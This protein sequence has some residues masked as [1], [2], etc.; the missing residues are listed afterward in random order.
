MKNISLY[1]I[2]VLLGFNLSC[3]SS[4]KKKTNPAISDSNFC[5]TLRSSFDSILTSPGISTLINDICK[6]G[7]QAKIDKIMY[8]DPSDSAQIISKNPNENVSNGYYRVYFQGGISLAEVP[9]SVYF[10]MTKTQVK[11]EL[12]AKLGGHYQYDPSINY[13]PT[14]KSESKV[15]YIYQKMEANNTPIEY[16]GVT[17]FLTLGP[18]SL[19]VVVNQLDEQENKKHSFKEEVLKM[20]SISIITQNAEGSKIYAAMTETANNHTDGKDCIKKAEDFF[21]KDI[22]RT[23]KNAIRYNAL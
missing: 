5:K 13:T 15:K 23:Y 6:D 16:A 22:E 4:S 2:L 7:D 20:Y 12:K 17:D 9:S 14:F 11:G 1:L 21:K 3:S 10:D 8:S 19:Y 18:D